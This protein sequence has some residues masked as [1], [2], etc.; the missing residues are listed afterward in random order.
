[1]GELVDNL[2]TFAIILLIILIIWS[3]IMGQTMLE[4]LNEIKEFVTGLK[5]EE[6][7]DYG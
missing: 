1:M 7:P 5:P 2:I 4:T 6:V 3:K